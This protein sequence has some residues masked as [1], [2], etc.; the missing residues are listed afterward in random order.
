MMKSTSGGRDHR[1]DLP[2][3]PMPVRTD[4]TVHVAQRRIE[5]AARLA[6]DMRPTGGKH[7]REDV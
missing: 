7:R 3:P 1:R 5:Q 6:D 2:P 4:P